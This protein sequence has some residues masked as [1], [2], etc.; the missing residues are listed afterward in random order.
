MDSLLDAL[1]PRERKAYA[2]LKSG[3]AMQAVPPAQ[4]DPAR[5]A[6]RRAYRVQD[7]GGE[8][9]DAAPDPDSLAFSVKNAARLIGVSRAILY[10]LIATGELRTVKIRNRRLVPRQALLELLAV[11]A[12]AQSKE[13]KVTT[14]KDEPVFPVGPYLPG[15]DK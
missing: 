6:P 4:S 1:S 11:G 13:N 10:L 7:R 2:K 9:N 15:N 12:K 14:D 5:P 3:Q 8:K